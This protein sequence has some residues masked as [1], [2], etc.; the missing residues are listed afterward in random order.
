MPLEPHDNSDFKTVAGSEFS[1]KNVGVMGK[2]L[3]LIWNQ[4]CWVFWAIH[5]KILGNFVIWGIFK[6]QFLEVL[7]Y[8]FGLKGCLKVW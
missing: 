4:N 3:K 7:A 2:K 5:V 8:F 6:F 1:S